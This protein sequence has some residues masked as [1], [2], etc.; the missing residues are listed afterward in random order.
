MGLD[1]EDW[2]AITM[3]SLQFYYTNKNF[4]EGIG[5]IKYKDMLQI[6]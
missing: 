2:D 4:Q 5:L 6:S 1:Q 3:L